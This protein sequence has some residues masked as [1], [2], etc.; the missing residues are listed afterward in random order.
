M[1]GRKSDL[2]ALVAGDAIER[3]HVDGS[4]FEVTCNCGGKAPLIADQ[5]I[6]C[7]QCLRSIAV[8]VLEGDPGYVLGAE[9]SGEPR[10]LPVQ[11][12][13]TRPLSSLSPAEYR[14][15]LDDMVAGAKKNKQ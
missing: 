13:T 4:E 12:S 14:R 6:R 11:G 2:Y 8:I 3:A 5:P 9:P 15:I 10:L 7:P 1:A